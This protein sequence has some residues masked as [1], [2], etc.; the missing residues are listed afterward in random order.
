M[1]DVL[2]LQPAGA[3]LRHVE[4]L[5]TFVPLWRRSDPITVVGSCTDIDIV[6]Q[7][8]LECDED[9]RMRFNN[10]AVCSMG[11]RQQDEPLD[12]LTSI[13]RGLDELVADVSEDEDESDEDGEYYQASKENTYYSPGQKLSCSYQLDDVLDFSNTSTASSS[14]FTPWAQQE[15]DDETDELIFQLEL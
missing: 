9:D 13:R 3:F 8:Q 2:Q 12:F 15:S 11:E 5:E 4:K 7:L 1:C 10:A 6:L 14:L